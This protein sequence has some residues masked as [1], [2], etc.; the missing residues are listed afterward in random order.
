[1][2]RRDN[3]P[4]LRIDYPHLGQPDGLTY[5]AAAEWRRSNTYLVKNNERILPEVVADVPDCFSPQ[6]WMQY[7]STLP[8]GGYRLPNSPHTIQDEKPAEKLA[9]QKRGARAAACDD[10]LLFFQLDQRSKGLCHPPPHAITPVSRLMESEHN[11]T[12]GTDVAAPR[13]S[14]ERPHVPF[15]EKL[16]DGEVRQASGPRR[17]T[18]AGDD[19]PGL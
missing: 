9:R 11:V 12:E 1:M 3:T 2:P 15:Q 16:H 13:N 17:G 7:L 4:N 19:A 6:E 8:L 18:Q 10:C 5:R 14:A